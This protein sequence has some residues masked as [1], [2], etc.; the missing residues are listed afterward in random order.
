MGFYQLTPV[1]GLS[2][3]S[4]KNSL[5]INASNRFLRFIIIALCWLI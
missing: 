1:S 2:D 3:E 4:N 5:I